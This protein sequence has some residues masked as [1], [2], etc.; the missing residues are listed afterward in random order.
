MKSI[1]IALILA[2]ALVGGVSCD[3]QDDIHNKPKPNDI[4]IKDGMLFVENND[5]WYSREKYTIAFSDA[6]FRFMYSI[7]GIILQHFTWIGNGIVGW[8]Q[9]YI[10]DSAKKADEL[11]HK[12]AKV[13]VELQEGLAKENKI[14]EVYNKMRMIEK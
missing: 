2:I 10:F 7:N 4:L 3:H 9:I 1:P 6:E 12:I 5:P 14:K 13:Q 8:K 11:A